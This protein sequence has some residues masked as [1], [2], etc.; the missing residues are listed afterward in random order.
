MQIKDT[1]LQLEF[2]IALY[3]YTKTSS[4]IQEVSQ[5]QITGG[6]KSITASLPYLY[7]LSLGTNI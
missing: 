6:W 7:T 1:A 2:F 4:L 3:N 5:P